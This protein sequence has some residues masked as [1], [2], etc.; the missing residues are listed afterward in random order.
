MLLRREINLRI[1]QLVREFKGPTEYLC[2]C[3]RP[4]CHESA[5]RLRAEEFA[6]VLEMPDWFLIASGHEP[7]GAIS[8]R[9]HGEYLLA[10]VQPEVMTT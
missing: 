10:Y 7:F 9:D 1:Y 3:A 2:E 6:A 4:T 5:L 8:I